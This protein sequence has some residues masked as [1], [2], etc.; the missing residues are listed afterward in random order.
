MWLKLI[1][2]SKSGPRCRYSTASYEKIFFMQREIR[3]D[4]I[5]SVGRRL[6]L[7]WQ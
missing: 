5:L 3:K 4:Y 2:V 1:H 7:S 6:D